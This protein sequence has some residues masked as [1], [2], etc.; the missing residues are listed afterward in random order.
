M[1]PI[2]SDK[3]LTLNL[4]GVSKSFGGIDAVV[5]VDMPVEVGESRA[6]IGP[7][8]AGKSTLFSLITGE[9][10]VDKG[11][12]VFFNEDLTTEPVQKR[13]ELGM[14]RTYQSS[15]LFMELSVRENLFLSVWKREKPPGGLFSMLF[16]S[17]KRYADQLEQLEDAAREVG[18][19]DKLDTKVLDMSHGEH[20][21]LE[22]AMTL[23]HRPKALL[24]DEPMAGLSASERILMTDLIMDLRSRITILVIE[25]DIDIAFSLADRVSVLHQGRI[26]ADGTP[27]EIRNNQRVQDIYTLNKEANSHNHA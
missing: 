6:L 18:L 2:R 7:N 16:R 22:L 12:I 9:T 17:W 14:G 4:T 15:N 27:E 25:H 23:A 19:I 10:P 24:L 3:S 11:K 5:D 8:G 1:T 26:I 20:R 13:I 21:Q